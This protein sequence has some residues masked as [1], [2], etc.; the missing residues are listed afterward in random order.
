MN[1]YGC[2]FLAGDHLYVDIELTQIRQDLFVVL[3]RDLQGY[4]A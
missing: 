3:R 2:S 1:D 4:P